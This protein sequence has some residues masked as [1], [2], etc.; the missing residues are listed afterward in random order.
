MTG[1]ENAV[2]LAESEIGGETSST[3]EAIKD[4]PATTS[5]SPPF[6]LKSFSISLGRF[7]DR[8]P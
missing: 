8:L 5:D 1:L 7:I 4:V 6:T 2:R 3:S